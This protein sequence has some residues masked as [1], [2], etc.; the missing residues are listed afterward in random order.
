M[1]VHNLTS[2]DTPVFFKIYFF[3]VWLAWYWLY[4]NFRL[5]DIPVLLV[6]YFVRVLS[7]LFL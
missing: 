5:Y 4:H 7:C 6:I 3:L 1:V 2:Y